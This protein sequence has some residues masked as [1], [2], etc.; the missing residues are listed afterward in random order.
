MNR[1]LN[2]IFKIHKRDQKANKSAGPQTDSP[3]RCWWCSNGNAS[4]QVSCEE[5]CSF[6]EMQI[7][8]EALCKTTTIMHFQP[9]CFRIKSL[10][11]LFAYDYLTVVSFC[12]LPLYPFLLW[13]TISVLSSCPVKHNDFHSWFHSWITVENVSNPICWSKYPQSLWAF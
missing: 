2:I 3:A 9:A 8:E 1:E 6:K 7:N 13:R 5:L 4:L 10:S 11:L 12:P